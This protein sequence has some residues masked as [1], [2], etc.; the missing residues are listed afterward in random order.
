MRQGNPMKNY[1][2]KKIGE[3]CPKPLY[4]KSGS[5]YFSAELLRNETVIYLAISAFNSI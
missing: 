5:K 4:I 2:F 3:W 1:G